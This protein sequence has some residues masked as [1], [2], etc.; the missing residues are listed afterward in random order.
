MALEDTGVDSSEDE[1][2]DM[3]A[4]GGAMVHMED[5]SISGRDCR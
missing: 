5:M 3:G 1:L 2:H 4:V